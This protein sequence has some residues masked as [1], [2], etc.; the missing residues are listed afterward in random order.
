MAKGEIDIRSKQPSGSQPFTWHL[1]HLHH[2]LLKFGDIGRR[3]CERVRGGDARTRGTAG[4]L[5]GASGWA[6]RTPPSAPPG[7]SHRAQSG[8]HGDGGDTR[9]RRKP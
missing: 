1:I 8:I 7:T 5:G 9:A 3:V 4:T 6:S 2:E